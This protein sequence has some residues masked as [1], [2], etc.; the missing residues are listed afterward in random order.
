MLYFRR[1]SIY[2]NRTIYGIDWFVIAPSLVYIATT[3]HLSVIEIGLITTG[4]Y[5]GL[6][7]SQLIS[8]VL[9]RK[10]GSGL[11]SFIG[12]FLLGFFTFLTAHSHNFYEIFWFR[13]ACG[14][15]SSLFSSPALSR[16]SEFMTR[17]ASGNGVGLYN[18]F[19]NVGAAIGFGGL[20][21]ADAYIGWRVSIEMLGFITMGA[22]LLLI[23][24]KGEKGI[25]ANNEG[26]VPSSE[27]SNASVLIVIS[28]SLVLASITEAVVGQLFVYYSVVDLKVDLY[29]ASTAL[30]AYWI[31]G[32][33]G[34]LLFGR[35]SHLFFKRKINFVAPVLLL[36]LSYIVVSFIEG[37]LELFLLSITMGFLSNGILSILYLSVIRMTHNSNT[38]PIYLGINNFIQKIIALGAPSLFAILSVLYSFRIS[39]ITLALIGIAPA[40]VLL[41]TRKI[42]RLE[43]FN[44]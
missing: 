24:H 43:I 15:G 31:A 1:G 18:S 23:P 29:I 12:M 44:V 3:L 7:P 10:F 42:P 39:W 13:I 28:V 16:L 32:I 8:G 37:D 5:I 20:A 35:L 30:S 21:F 27:R 34:A 38:T 33:F 9:S 2:L 14:I 11:I 4:F 17:D 6:V 22:A 40:L 41:L 19:F 26:I 36:A 25:P